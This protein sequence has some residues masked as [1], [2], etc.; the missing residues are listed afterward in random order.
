MRMLQIYYLIGDCGLGFALVSDFDPMTKIIHLLV[1]AVCC[2]LRT[3]LHL[4]A[5]L[6]ESRKCSHPLAI[7]LADCQ[8]CC[9]SAA[10][11][12]SCCG[13]R[14]GCLPDLV[15]LNQKGCCSVGFANCSGLIQKVHRSVSPAA[16]IR[17]FQ[18]KAEADLK[19]CE[20]QRQISTSAMKAL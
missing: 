9:Q 3:D 8:I 18:Q 16:W 4:A 14:R 1:E 2:S 20:R 7:Q 5:G 6:A 10:A 12:Y 19:H 13:T 15:L 11:G 17:I